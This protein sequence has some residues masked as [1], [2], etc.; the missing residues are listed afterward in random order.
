MILSGAI[1]TWLGIKLL[2]RLSVARFR[3]IF[4]V[5]LTLLAIQLAWQGMSVILT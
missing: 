4:K 5:I 1:G 3:V 2:K